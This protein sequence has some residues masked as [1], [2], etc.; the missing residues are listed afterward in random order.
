VLDRFAAGSAR[1]K[2]L[3]EKLRALLNAAQATGHVQRVF[4]W[5]SFVTGK[6]S[7]N[8]LDV[9]LVLDAA[10]DPAKV[11]EE[12]KP[13]FAHAQARVYFSADVFW[14]KASIGQAALDLWPS[15]HRG[16]DVDMIKND[17]QLAAAQRAV[18][19]LQQVLLAARK[20]HAPDEYRSMAEPILLELQRRE[21]EI[22]E[23]LSRTDADAVA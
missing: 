12:C 19:N 3:G 23:Y 1:R 22:L 20:V 4:L 6:E 14:T 2:W 18:R 5:G 9:L 16:G 10:F 7:P 17:D 15:R 13:L 8:D 11:P 21:Q